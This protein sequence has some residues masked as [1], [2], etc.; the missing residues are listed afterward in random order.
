MYVA[1]K[2]Q[3]KL[4]LCKGNNLP[5]MCLSVILAIW[6]LMKKQLFCDM[7]VTKKYANLIMEN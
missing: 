4:L 1:K 5:W 6:N 3:L 7:L 2:I